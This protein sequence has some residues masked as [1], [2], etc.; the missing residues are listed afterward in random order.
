MCRMEI[1]KIPS[2]PLFNKSM[3]AT[4]IMRK[5]G[6]FLGARRDAESL[7]F[8]SF[9]EEED[10]EGRRPEEEWRMG[11]NARRFRS[12]RP[13]QSDDP[14]YQNVPDGNSEISVFS[15]LKITEQR[16]DYFPQV[17]FGGTQSRRVEGGL[18]PRRGTAQ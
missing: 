10:R 1:P 13:S 15:V 7:E 17:S 8:C 6:L 12:I 16:Y 11:V 3:R 9:D 14:Y 4:H 2:H 5:H 18:L